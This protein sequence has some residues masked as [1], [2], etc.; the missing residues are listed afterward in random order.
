MHNPQ[1][2]PREAIV[3]VNYRC[4][5]RCRM[6]DIWRVNE[7]GA[8]AAEDY[9]RLPAG[10]ENVGI[11]GGEPFLRRDIV[12][13]VRVVHET[14]E[15]PQIIINT[16][17]YLTGRIAA[18]FRAFRAFDP[19]IGIGISVDGI[20]KT[21]DMMRGTRHAFDKV[22]ATIAA[23]KDQNVRNIRLSFTVTNENV[24]ELPQVY[25][26][27]RRL[28]VQ[29]AST[30]AHNSDHYF[31]TSANAGV[32]RVL[33]RQAYDVVNRKELSSRSIKSWFRAYFNEGVLRFNDRGTRLTACSAANDFFFL[34]PRGEVYPCVILP[35]VLGNIMATPFDELWTGSAASSI[36]TEIDGCEKCWMMCSAR[37]G[38]KRHPFAASAW[39]AK[40]QLRRL[41]V[42]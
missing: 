8:L 40:E 12:D 10:L 13:L 35:K 28:G 5:A 7:D 9:R 21:H 20:G 29:F 14:A 3:A 19:R 17:G 41:A 30:V 25:E 15:R 1:P 38:L 4:N 6:C 39:V 26:L 34:S 18:A 27:A 23:L 11:T 24:T 33:L 16:N 32:D 42:H 36:R 31:H 2:R 37:T 22:M